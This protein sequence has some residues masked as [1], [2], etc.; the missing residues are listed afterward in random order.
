MASTNPSQTAQQDWTRTAVPDAAPFA[1]FFRAALAV[2]REAGAIIKAAFEDGQAPPNPNIKDANDVDLVTATDQAVEALIQSRLRD[3]FPDY[4]FIGEETVAANNGQAPPLTA[5]PTIICD[6]VDGTT[7][8]VHGFPFV[9]TALALVVDHTPIVGIVYNP[10]LDQ[11]Y[12]AHKGYGAWCNGQSL[13]RHRAA[14][15]MDARAT[16]FITEGGHD[17][18]PIAMDAKIGTWRHALAADGKYPPVRGIRCTGSGA[19]NLCMIARGAAD[20]YW[21][22]GLHA[23]DMAAAAV[24]VTEAG[25]MVVGDEALDADRRTTW[26][27]QATPF[28]VMGRKAMA[29]R[30]RDVAFMRETIERVIDYPCPRD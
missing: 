19:L 15:A 16:L 26:D 9:C 10:I 18:S 24:I 25:G 11:L 27:P 13:P 3:A 5:R 14:H 23:W 17:R 20:V 12:V 28:D 6:P 1:P 30:K 29:I 8:F 22:V 7:N 21:E 4:A 2:A